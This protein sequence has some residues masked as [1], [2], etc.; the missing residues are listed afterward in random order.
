[1]QSLDNPFVAV[2]ARKQRNLKKKVDRIQT[3]EE[4]YRAGKTLD[5]EQLILV[6]SKPAIE[7]QLADFKVIKAQL[8]DVAKQQSEEEEKKGKKTVEAPIELIAETT[9]TEV[10][11]VVASSTQCDVVSAT[12]SATQCSDLPV[13]EKK[14]KDV[15]TVQTTVTG[16]DATETNAAP[17][18]DPAVY[19]GLLD[20]QMKKLLKALHVY[21]RY[22][23]TTQST[24]PV[25]VDFF[26]K[27]LLG[28]TSI[29]GFDHT[30]QGSLRS[31]GYYV[32]DELSTQFEA[33]R[34]VKY[35]QISDTI[36]ELAL[37]ME[38]FRIATPST[39]LPKFNIK[40][41]AAL[42]AAPPS[43]IPVDA[44][45]VEENSSGSSSGRNAAQLS[46][47]VE[48][49]EEE[50]ST[51]L[52]PCLPVAADI[53]S[54]PVT[55]LKPPGQENAVSQELGS[56]ADETET[57]EKTKRVRGRKPRERKPREGE[58]SA[59]PAPAASVEVPSNPSPWT[60][61]TPSP[62]PASAPPSAPVSSSSSSASSSFSSSSSSSST[63]APSTED[64][65][66]RSSSAEPRGRRERGGR[67]RKD[68]PR[69]KKEGSAAPVPPVEASRPPPHLSYKE[70]L[71]GANAETGS[72]EKE[73]DDGSK[74]KRSSRGRGSR[75]GGEGPK[76][77]SEKKPQP[78]SSSSDNGSSE[79]VKP[80]QQQRQQGQG[81]GQGQQRKSGASSSRPKPT[82]SSNSNAT[83]NKLK[84]AG[85]T[86]TM[87]SASSTANSAVGSKKGH[88]PAKE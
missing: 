17:V 77:G 23:D 31:A 79:H 73:R 62:T 5:E 24:L 9:Q 84:A 45:P 43:A 10:A 29:S 74:R 8:E 71:N 76:G 63:S 88:P 72:T 81:Q 68:R 1:M 2:V 37:E 69:E 67:D 11:E 75:S 66:A 32:N 13:V 70:K 82:P 80:P 27:T 58:A 12:T 48:E 6:S 60:A 50:E 59:P 53:E 20:A 65:G 16:V 86:G 49:E 15:P 14:T 87:A 34:G 54:Q 42:V 40:P 83:S 39:S 44:L 28:Q 30:L 4:Q 25:N 3:I 7:K 51:A 47:I 56:A 85:P 64:N 36:D 55:K 35:S 26:G 21:L 38:G 61:L 22:G 41:A 18:F 57:P 19:R 33:I 78:V 52:H 46:A